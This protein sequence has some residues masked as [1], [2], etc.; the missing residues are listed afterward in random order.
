MASYL[1]YSAGHFRKTYYADFQDVS[2]IFF[3]GILAMSGLRL[4]HDCMS[5]VVA[6]E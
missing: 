5:D 2:Y 1:I 3:L 4:S 6:H